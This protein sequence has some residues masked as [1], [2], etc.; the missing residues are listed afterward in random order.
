MASSHKAKKKSS[1]QAKRKRAPYLDNRDLALKIMG[2]GG[3]Q[4]VKAEVKERLDPA[5]AHQILRL[6]KDEYK[7]KDK[8]IPHELRE[9]AAKKRHGHT[10]HPTKPPHVGEERWYETGKNVRIGVPLVT[11]GKKHKDMTRVV[12][13]ADKI[14]IYR[15]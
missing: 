7:F 10:G 5:R 12:F 15:K 14:V 6:L 9:L 11:L 2:P 1:K 13:G 3:F 8:D 4:K